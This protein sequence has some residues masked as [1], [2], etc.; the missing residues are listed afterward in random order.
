MCIFPLAQ[1]TFGAR[2]GK[3]SPTLMSSALFVRVGA[4]LEKITILSP[5][6]EIYTHTCCARGILYFILH[7]YNIV[8]LVLSL[9]IR[10]CV[11]A[12]AIQTKN[13]HQRAQTLAFAWPNAQHENS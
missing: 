11:H 10:R 13:H 6:H 3:V 4:T 9:P 8:K 7:T 5:R 2:G 12:R 1:I